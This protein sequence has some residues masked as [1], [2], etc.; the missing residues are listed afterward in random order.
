[1]CA[2]KWRYKNKK[3]V[4]KMEK[5]IFVEQ[6]TLN[7]EKRIRSAAKKNFHGVNISTIFDQGRW[8]VILNPFESEEELIYSVIDAAG[9]G[10][11]FEK[12]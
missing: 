5:K 2:V 9:H 12:A 7:M 6:N 3:E 8:W 4:F 10:F 1:M 11:S